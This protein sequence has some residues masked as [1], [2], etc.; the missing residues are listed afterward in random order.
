VV[1]DEALK[2]Q[3][4]FDDFDVITSQAEP[5][6]H[7][8]DLHR[9]GLPSLSLLHYISVFRGGGLVDYQGHVTGQGIWPRRLHW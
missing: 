5:Q 2:A 1:V 7:G 9:M 3:V 4:V 6:L 8:L